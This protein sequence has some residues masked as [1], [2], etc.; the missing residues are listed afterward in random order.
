MGKE[1]AG[2]LDALVKTIHL[3]SDATRLRL[4]LLL[5]GGESNVSELCD[6]L[7][8]S[9][10]TTS[11][12][13]GLLRMGCVVEIRRQGKHVYYRL[14]APVSA[15]GEVRLTAGRAVVSVRPR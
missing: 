5:S 13:L 11:H 8:C 3:L 4:L 9:Q 7:G 1:A 12:H 10:P 2:D 14:A 15:T 6:R